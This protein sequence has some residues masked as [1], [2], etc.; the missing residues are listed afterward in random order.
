MALKIG[1]IVGSL[2]K[3]SF[4]K[5]FMQNFVQVCPK[6]FECSFIPLENLSLYNQDLDT[7]YPPSWTEFK[8]Q[9]KSCDAIIFATPE[10]NRSIPGVLKNAIDIGTR[11]P[12]QNSFA[13]IPAAVISVSP[14]KL[15]AFG[16]H[17]HL[18]QVLVALG[19]PTMPQPEMYIG[20]VSDLLDAQGKLEEKTLNFLKS[21]GED[22]NDWIH[23]FLP[24]T[25]KVEKSRD[26]EL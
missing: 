25:K 18:R 12:K 21:F 9:I 8:N 3:E 19:M 16:A 20:N 13:K 15:S 14:G 11:P 26:M 6:N 1:I 2:R 17:H 5:K 7:N 22:F 24:E 23:K 10:Y 4:T